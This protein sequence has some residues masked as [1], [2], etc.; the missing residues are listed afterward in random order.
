MVRFSGPGPPIEDELPVRECPAL[1]IGA[2][3]RG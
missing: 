1:G 2:L 3:S